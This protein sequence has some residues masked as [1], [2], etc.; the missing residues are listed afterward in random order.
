M[1]VVLLVIRASILLGFFLVF[2]R[3][4]RRD[5]GVVVVLAVLGVAVADAVLYADTTASAQRSIFHPD[6]L[7]QSFRLTQ[8]VVPLALAARLSVQGWPRRIDASAPLWLA[9]FLWVGVCTAAGLLEGHDAGRA[10]RQT[11]IIVHVGGGMALAASVPV[12]DYV[13]GSAVPRFIQGCAVAASALFAWDTWGVPMAI[14]AIP[15]LPL[16]EFGRYGAD[17]ATLFSSIGVLGLVLAVSRPKNSPHRVALLV[18]SIVLL[19]SHVASAQ[20]AA[21]LGLYVI[22]ILLLLVCCTPTAR[23]RIRVRASQVAMVAAAVLAAFLAVIFTTTLLAASQAPQPGPY[24]SGEGE[25]AGPALGATTRQGSIQS[26]YNQW[27]I[28]RKEIAE[29]PFLGHGLGVEISY[30]EVAEQGVVTSDIT[31][32]IVLDLVLRTGIV[33]LVLAASGVVVVWWRG[34]LTWRWHPDNRVAAWAIAAVTLSAGLLAK[35]LVESIF[36]KHRLALL[37]GVVMGLAISAVESGP[38]MHGR[39]WGIARTEESRWH[40]RGPGRHRVSADA[41]HA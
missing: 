27:E 31:H 41:T 19:L 40:R 29:A 18:S 37:L 2:R 21:R 20:R 8:L 24:D 17:A 9:F 16:L 38:A 1:T 4:E 10:L 23:R 35:G 6:F 22:L 13:T 15:D 33:G 14:T 5:R 25:G 36:E 30:Y 3:L 12:W 11:A 28:A 7:G 34:I 39:W 26:R 32:N